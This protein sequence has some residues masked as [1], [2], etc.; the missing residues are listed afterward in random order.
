MLASWRPT[1]RCLAIWSVRDGW[2]V[3]EN[4]IMCFLVIISFMDPTGRPPPGLPAVLLP[5]LAL[6]LWLPPLR[7]PLHN[8]LLGPFHRQGAVRDIPGDGRARSRYRISSY[9][10][11]SNQHRIR[12]D[13]RSVADDRP[14]LLVPVEV[15]GD[16]SRADIRALADLSVTDIREVRNLTS[17]TDSGRLDLNKRAGLGIRC[18]HGSGSDVGVRPDG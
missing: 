1:S 7:V 8:P 18:Q 5:S 16:R 2:A 11:R 6:P 15:A 17:F 9:P 13:E 10:D 3:P 14:M 12:T 4:S